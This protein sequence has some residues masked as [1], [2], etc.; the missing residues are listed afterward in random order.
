MYQPMLCN[1]KELARKVEEDHGLF[2]AKQISLRNIL[3]NGEYLESQIYPTSL[4]LDDQ[5]RHR[6]CISSYS[7]G[8]R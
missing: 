7:S 3:Y 6:V 2:F 4:R 5:N 1:P 8:Q